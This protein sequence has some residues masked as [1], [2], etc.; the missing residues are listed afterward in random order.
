MFVRAGDYDLFLAGRLLLSAFLD[1]GTDR[2]HS[3]AVA[4]VGLRTEHSVP[5]V[6]Y[7]ATSVLCYDMAKLFWRE[8]HSIDIYAHGPDRN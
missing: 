4:E 1:C 3:A 6:A 7:T 2:E 5:R 8:S